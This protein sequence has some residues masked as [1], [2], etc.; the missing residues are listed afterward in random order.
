VVLRVRD[1]GIGMTPGTLERFV[2]GRQGSIA[3]RALAA[4]FQ[5]HLVKP[6]DLNE[7]DGALRGARSQTPAE[8]RVLVLLSR[9]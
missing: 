6:V 4:G 1:N 8:R 9:P 2:Q 5:R 7:L 3:Q